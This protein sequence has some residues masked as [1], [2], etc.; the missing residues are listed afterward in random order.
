MDIHTQHEAWS[1][2]PQLVLRSGA[3][4]HEGLSDD[5]QNGVHVVRR[6]DVEDELG[7]LQDVDPE[8]Q[9]KAER[10]TPLFYLMY[11]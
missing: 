7:V 2:P 10:K 4:V 3:R 6:L 9:R 11:R 5:G 1:H 8:P